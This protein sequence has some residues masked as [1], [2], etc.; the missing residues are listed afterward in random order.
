MLLLFL[1]Q[2]KVDVVDVIG[3]FL[4]LGHKK[5][6]SY[7]IMSIGD[8]EAFSIRIALDNTPFERP[9]SHDL[10]KNLI[11]IAGFRVEKVVIYDVKNGAYL[12]RIHLEKGFFM[13]KQRVVLDSRPSDAVALALRLKV[14]IFVMPHLLINPLEIKPDTLRTPKGI[15]G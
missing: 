9:L 11:D 8:S 3:N 14:P 13:F 15:E 12:A 5:T 7:V 1:N 2:V 10:M 4:V 6:H